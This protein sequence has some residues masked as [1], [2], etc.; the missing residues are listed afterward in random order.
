MDLRD[1]QRNLQQELGLVRDGIRDLTAI[2]R[3]TP[4]LARDLSM[5]QSATVL[6]TSGA[7]SHR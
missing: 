6:S 4:Q 3:E 2:V 1:D 7:G 5:T